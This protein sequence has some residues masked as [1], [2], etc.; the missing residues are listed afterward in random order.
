MT[1]RRFLWDGKHSVTVTI[2][3]EGWNA[4]LDGCSVGVCPYRLGS[5]AAAHWL[6]GWNEAEPEAEKCTKNT[7]ISS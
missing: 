5:D 1:R 7:T 3:S 6:A 4:H 2:R